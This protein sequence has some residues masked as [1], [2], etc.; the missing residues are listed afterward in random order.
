MVQVG[1]LTELQKDKLIGQIY[2]TDSYFNPIQDID[3]NWVIS[4]EEINY[5]INEEFFWVKNLL[6]IDYNPKPS[7]PLH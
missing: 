3:N 1:L 2:D 5:C 7:P 6:L 4:I